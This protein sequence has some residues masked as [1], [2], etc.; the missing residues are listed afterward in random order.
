[1]QNRGLTPPPRT[2]GEPRDVGIDLL[3]GMSMLYI[4]G[5]WHL[6]NYT[7]A[8]PKYQNALTVRLT[9]IVLGAFTLVSG[10][11][12]GKR[13]IEAKWTAALGFYKSRLTRIYPPFAVALLCFFLSGLVTSKTM[14]ASL[15]LSAMFLGPPPMT[16]WYITMIV[17]FY[18]LAP[19]LL[20]A[21]AC[22][23]ASFAGASVAIFLLFFGFQHVAGTGDIRM[24]IYFPCF[25][26]G[27]LISGIEMRRLARALPVM[28]VLA[29]LGVWLG[30]MEV[31]S[32]ESSYFSMPLA[33]FGALSAFA[34]CMK[35]RIKNGW[36]ASALAHLSFASY[37]MY[38]THRPI[39]LYLHQWYE[40]ES[41]LGQVA[42]LIL[43]CLPLIVAISWALQRLYDRQ[44]KVKLFHA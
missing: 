29:M 28:V 36:L 6:F 2:F 5:Y 27:I 13:P 19:L 3:K 18:V 32:L 35:I 26:L 42:Y 30:K 25:A 22:G 12:I 37:F 10:Y 34:L 4:V 1:M 11:L 39:F 21:K 14:V 24:S 41:G 43:F 15:T 16:L 33:A 31:N 38:L 8:F 44:V 17:V 20:Q 23:Y 7:H 40:P 9:V